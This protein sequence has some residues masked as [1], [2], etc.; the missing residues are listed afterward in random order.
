MASAGALGVGIALVLAG[1]GG[2][3]DHRVARPAHAPANDTQWFSHDAPGGTHILVGVIRAAPSFTGSRP[4]I[5]VVPGTDGLSVDY[6]T[7]GH[8]LARAGFNVA[9]GCWFADAPTSPNS[10]LIGCAGA[11][12]FK[13][14]TDPAVADL[15]ALVAAAK[16]GLVTDDL[17]L[18]GFSRGGGIVLLRAA[19]GATDPVVSI[20]GEI[21]GTTNLGTAPGEVNIVTRAADIHAPVLLLHGEDDPV[22]PVTQARHLEAALRALHADVTAK[23]NTGKGHGLIA[24]AETRRDLINRITGFLCRQDRCPVA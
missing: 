14:V 22:V 19:H 17:A 23:Y 6:D 13:G 9:I 21:E 5:L 10:P 11:P 2:G 7:F 4:S 20:A 18:V 12:A 3:G 1:C 8:E 16:D 15:D 24:D